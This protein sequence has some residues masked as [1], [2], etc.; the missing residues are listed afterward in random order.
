MVVK[1][2]LSRKTKMITALFTLLFITIFAFAGNGIVN[3]GHL[4]GLN[5]TIIVVTMGVYLFAYFNQSRALELTNTELIIHTRR[6]DI[7]I[8]IADII[9]IEATKGGFKDQIRVWGIN[10][11]FGAQGIY[12]SKIQRKRYQYFVTNYKER[13]RIET[14]TKN[15][16]VSCENHL[17]FIQLVKEAK[18]KLGH[19]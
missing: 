16:M 6:R 4:I 13:F 8:N 18:A 3:H 7:H 9:E 10:G 5:I 1:S 11:L 15:Y 12:Y 19:N 14:K 17:Q 2:Y